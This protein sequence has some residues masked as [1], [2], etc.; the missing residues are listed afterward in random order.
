MSDGIDDDEL[1]K[2][3]I[4]WFEWA[5]CGGK[6]G[7]MRER[8]FAKVLVRMRAQRDEVVAA[9]RAHVNTEYADEREA[10]QEEWAR[11]AEAFT[12]SMAVLAKYPEK[13]QDGG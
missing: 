2:L 5:A 7:T 13:T 1:E 11:H 3:T 4:E 8:D 9:L 10:T 6:G 12:N